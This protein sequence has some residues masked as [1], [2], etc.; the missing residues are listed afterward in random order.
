VSV[1]C[2]RETKIE[3]TTGAASGGTV[4][5]K[6]F[7]ALR[8]GEPLSVTRIETWFVVFACETDG[9]HVKTPFVALR[10]AP[11]GAC[12]IAKASV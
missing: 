7:E 4:T 2:T 3:L 5:V 11:A 1:V 10:A 8:P 12:E 9:R 6:L